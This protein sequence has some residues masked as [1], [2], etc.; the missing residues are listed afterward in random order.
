MTLNNGTY[1]QSLPVLKNA[2]TVSGIAGVTVKKSGVERLSDIE[3][4]VELEFDGNFDAGAILTFTVETDAIAG[5]D[6]PALIARVV[7]GGGKESVIASTESPLTET[8]L[9]GSV[10]KLTLNGATYEQSNYDIRETVTVS[11]IKGVTFHW[12]D[13]N[14]VSD[15]ELKIEL[16]FDGDFDANATLT[17]T[18][19]ADAIAG[20]DGPALTARV[21]VT[22]GQESVVAST[23]FP[24]TEAT[25]NG[26]VVTLTFNGR[27]YE[28]SIFK[29]RDSV[30]VSGIAGVT[31]P[32][33]GLNRKSDTELTVELDFNGNINTDS[34]LIFTVGAEAILRYEGPALTV[35]VAVTGSK[36][37]LV[38]STDSSLTEATLDGGIVTLTLKGTQYERSIF[39]IRDSVKVSGIAGVT[40]P[41]HGL[42][43]KSDTELTVELDFNGNFDT[44]STLT[45]IVGTDA[46]VDYSGPAFTD[47]V[48]VTSSKKSLTATTE[49]PLTEATLDGGIVTLTLKGTQYERSIFKI[50]DSVKVSGIA[51]VTLPWHGF[52]QEERYRTHG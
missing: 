50:R 34:T 21:I 42:K 37:S 3:I 23:E 40:I 12:F 14:R 47:Q 15:T 1:A 43:R 20:Y 51:G 45:F 38:A 17:F 48:A 49:F 29:I 46:I 18:V 5:Y 13:L 19:E 35:Q 44:D 27:T 11:G 36:K 41:W 22:G 2:V 24:L 31:I 33:H 28:R 10:V 16:T 7:V 25:L 26:S 4:T 9:N 30:K 52:R 32:W 8:T 6:G 39:K